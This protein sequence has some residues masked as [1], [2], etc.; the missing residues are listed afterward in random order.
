MG[1]REDRKYVRKTFK[2]THLDTGSRKS[3]EDSIPSLNH[4]ATLGR[5]CPE[6]PL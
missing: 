3:L 4:F 6:D 1:I 2:T 5:E